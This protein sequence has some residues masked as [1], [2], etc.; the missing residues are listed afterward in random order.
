M[1]F[2]DGNND[3]EML[4]A[5]HY[6]VAMGNALDSVKEAAPYTT[7]G[8]EEDGIAHFIETHFEW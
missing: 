3:L 7:I 2:G 5:V 4:L 1:A 6:G 8:N